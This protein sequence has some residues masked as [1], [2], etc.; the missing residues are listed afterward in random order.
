MEREAT[1]FLKII[2]TGSIKKTAVAFSTEPSSISRQLSALEHRLGVKLIN[3]STRGSTPTEAGSVYYEGLRK[4]VDEQQALEANVAGQADVPRGRLVVT[5]PVDFGA[6]FVAPVL[7]DMQETYSGLIVEMLL[8]SNKPDLLEQSIDVAIR[9]GSLPNSSLICR[10]IGV[11]PRV[12]V[13]SPAYL[14]Q[15][16][17]PESPKDLENH[18]FVFYSRQQG[19]SMIEMTGKNG[20]ER[21]AVSGS[22]TVN[23]MT[24][25]IHLVE[26]GAGLHLGPIWAFQDGLTSGRLVKVLPKY[27]LESFPLHA[28]YNQ[29]SFVPAKVRQFIDRMIKNVPDNMR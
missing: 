7:R 27:Q 19:Q 17:T 5:A 23:S 6:R 9:I 11:V 18:R 3:R 20:K 1:T 21:V 26:S 12:L 13:A 28:V 2:E 22:F 15:Y 4:L 16:G 29:T 10:K 25:I 8:G 24:A 14:G